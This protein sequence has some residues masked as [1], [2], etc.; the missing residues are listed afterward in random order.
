MGAPDAKQV[1]EILSFVALLDKH[2]SLQD[3]IDQPYELFLEKLSYSELKEFIKVA[4]KSQYYKNSGAETKSYI[5]F[6]P[7]TFIISRHHSEKDSAET[8]RALLRRQKGTTRFFGEFFVGAHRETLLKTLYDKG[9]DEVLRVVKEKLGKETQGARPGAYDKRLEEII[10]GQLK[11]KGSDFMRPYRIRIFRTIQ[12]E[13]R[14]DSNRL[15]LPP[16]SVDE[17][18]FVIEEAARESYAY[19]PPDFQ[20]ASKRLRVVIDWYYDRPKMVQEA[21]FEHAFEIDLLIDDELGDLSRTLPRDVRNAESARRLWKIANRLLANRRLIEKMKV[22]NGEMGY[23]GSVVERDKEMIKRGRTISGVTAVAVPLTIITGGRALP[24]LARAT[25]RGVVNTG[26]ATAALTTR[27]AQHIV[28][29][30]RT[31]ATVTEAVRYLGSTAWVFYL[32]RAAQIN[33]GV[34][35]GAEIGLGF[36][37][38]DAGVYSLSPDDVVHVARQVSAD[39]YQALKL[40]IKTTGDEVT[41]AVQE[42]KQISREVFEGDFDKGKKLFVE[43]A[44]ETAEVAV[45]KTK[46]PDPAPTQTANIDPAQTVSTESRRPPGFDTGRAKPGRDVKPGAM[47]D[48]TES[49]QETLSR[50]TEEWR[51]ATDG[52][53]DDAERAIDVPVLAPSEQST[54]IKSREESL[55]GAPQQSLRARAVPKGKPQ[56][57]LVTTD[58]L[59]ETRNMRKWAKQELPIGSTD[60]MFPGKIVKKPP[61]A[62]HIVSVE[63][64]REMPGFAQLDSARQEEIV[65]TMGNFVAL[66]EFANTSKKQKSFAAWKVYLDEKG[67]KYNEQLLNDLIAKEKELEKLIQSRID[68]ALKEQ[69]AE[70][71]N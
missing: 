50:E 21:Q 7:V 16:S 10:D 15:P 67:I 14:A 13:R 51:R 57:G 41:A 70:G 5:L 2:A 45:T 22:L 12:E 24:F 30:I 61:H 40:E 8:L 42:V 25:T 43:K 62:D 9:R 60:P 19:D 66:S 26:T 38:N 35:A 18:V 34:L 58:N 52:R 44:G 29:A 46:K 4:L 59:T 28:I 63:R 69:I 33:Q 32:S 17:V 39:A 20:K 36:T 27:A 11:K 1:D 31:S 56:R 48:K 23:G 6:K 68:R 55:Y 37:G 54:K 65:R 53:P 49:A 71:A 3:Q 64:I 47:A